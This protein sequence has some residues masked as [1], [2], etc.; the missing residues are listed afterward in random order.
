MESYF[1]ELPWDSCFHHGDKTEIS[2][3][4]LQEHIIKSMKERISELEGALSDEVADKY[5][6]KATANRFHSEVKDLNEQ[7]LILTTEREKFKGKA[8]ILNQANMKLALRNNDQEQCLLELRTEV[9]ILTK[10]RKN[11]DDMSLQIEGLT[12]ELKAAEIL[13]KEARNELS[14]CQEEL[15]G[16]PVRIKNRLATLESQLRA[17]FSKEQQLHQQQLSQLQKERASNSKVIENDQIQKMTS[18]IS[19]L[20]SNLEKSELLLQECARVVT[21]SSLAIEKR[22]TELKKMLSEYASQGIELDEAKKHNLYLSILL[23]HYQKMSVWE[24]G[25]GDSIFV[26]PH[27][28]QMY[29]AST[30]DEVEAV[31]TKYPVFFALTKNGT[32]HVLLLSE[33]EK[34]LLYPVG[35]M[36][37]EYLLDTRFHDDA[38]HAIKSTTIEE[39]N[40]A[41]D[42]YV[43]SA[44]NISHAATLLDVEWC[45]PLTTEKIME[46]VLSS[47]Q[48]GVDVEAAMKAAKRVGLLA[49]AQAKASQDL[50]KKTR[51][52]RR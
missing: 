13:L 38:F 1:V 34:E 41:V 11:T 10:D 19:R 44:Q 3:N 8:E 28:P 43:T 47:E 2:I 26:L 17:E 4:A 32:G 18:E 20:T 30:N 39:Y 27:N 14:R 48:N 45:Q 35:T 42:N 46:A 22:D 21:D 29:Q 33:D 16:E 12:S 23:N 15:K 49:R 40:Q 25:E 24:S 31:S 9:A 6:Y 51:K 37:K 36:P 50:R 5:R 7:K 52:K